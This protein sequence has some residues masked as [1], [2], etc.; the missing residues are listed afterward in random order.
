VT[1]DGVWIGK[2]IYWPLIPHDSELQVITAPP[3]IST[4]HKSPQHPLSV[5]QPAVSSPAVPWQRFLT[6]EILQLH[7][8]RFYLHSLPCRTAYR[9]KVKDALRLTVSQSVSLGVEP[10]LGLMTRYL[11]LF[12]N[13]GLVFWG[14][15]SEERTGLSLIYAAGPCHRSFYRV[16]VP[17]DSRPYFTISDLRLP[18]S[19]PPTTRRVTEEVFDPASTR[20]HELTSQMP[21]D[22][23][24]LTLF[25]DYSISARTT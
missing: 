2:R 14:P 23:Y 6:V 15:L 4:I 19:S 1:V 18:F 7:A 5:S 10:Y 22:A 12:H 13:Y 3:L 11:L 9:L 24:R 8:L 20:V 25:L 17:W 21:I 16:R